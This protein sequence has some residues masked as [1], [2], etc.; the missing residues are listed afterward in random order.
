MPV[1]IDSLIGMSFGNSRSGLPDTGYLLAPTDGVVL[2]M[3]THGQTCAGLATQH[4]YDRRVR[5]NE[6]IT[7]QLLETD[8]SAAFSREL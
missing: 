1:D 8:A 5:W 2:R 4:C 3:L 6:G 7:W